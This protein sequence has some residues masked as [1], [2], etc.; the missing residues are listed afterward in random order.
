MP[1]LLKFDSN[2]AD[3]FNIEG[4][5]AIS[6]AEWKSYKTKAK[7]AIGN[8]PHEYYFGTNESITFSGYKE[9]LKSFKATT[10]SEEEYQFLL[11]TFP[12]TSY[13]EFNGK[14][15]KKITTR[16]QFGKIPFYSDEQWGE[17]EQRD[18]ESEE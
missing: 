8:S 4:F 15:F 12:H 7:K 3:E 6:E 9:Y 2:Y 10:I 5:V 1:V 17:I 13:E 18:E 14:D 16:V 11:K